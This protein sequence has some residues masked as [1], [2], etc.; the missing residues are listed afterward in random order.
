MYASPSTLTADISIHA[1][2][3]GSDITAA[4][5]SSSS[6]DFNPR[7]PCGERLLNMLSINFLLIFQS[8]LPVWGATQ[9]LKKTLGNIGISIHAPRVGSDWISTVPCGKCRISIHAPRVGS[10][11][12]ETKANNQLAI[13]IHA[14]R[15]GSDSNTPLVT[16]IS[17]HFNPRSPCG[18]RPFPPVACTGGN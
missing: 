1:P 11:H 9:A 12:H 2:R 5:S 4:I 6:S 18:E 10:D 13:S 14:P 3:V 17:S 7:S 8:T 16:G 15:V